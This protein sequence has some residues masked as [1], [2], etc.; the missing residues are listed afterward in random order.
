MGSNEDQMAR[1]TDN[2]PETLYSKTDIKTN[3]NK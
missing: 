3:T 1:L 2:E